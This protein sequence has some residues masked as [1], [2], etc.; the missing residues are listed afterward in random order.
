MV[1]V[2]KYAYDIFGPGVNLAAR[3]ENTAE[4]MQIVISADTWAPRADEYDCTDLGEVDIKGSGSQ[5]IYSLNP[6]S[7]GRFG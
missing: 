2:S 4:P 6:E 7:S 1:G 3:M 5:T